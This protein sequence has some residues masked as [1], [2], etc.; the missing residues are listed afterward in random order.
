MG[1][2]RDGLGRGRIVEQHAAAAVDLRVDEA[3]SEQTAL[4]IDDQV[5]ARHVVRRRQCVDGRVAYP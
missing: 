5:G 2:I 1:N 3:R 4:Q